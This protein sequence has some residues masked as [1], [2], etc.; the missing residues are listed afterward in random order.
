M[1]QDWSVGRWPLSINGP[2]NNGKKVK[3]LVETI[4]GLVLH[5]VLLEEEREVYLMRFRSIHL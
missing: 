5:D 1:N 4:G 2:K 3:W